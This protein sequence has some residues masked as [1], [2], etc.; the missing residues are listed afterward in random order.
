M[1]VLSPLLM[2]GLETISDPE[3]RDRFQIA[4]DGLNRVYEQKGEVQFKWTTT[5]KDKQKATR[6]KARSQE[7]PA[8][9]PREF[10]CSQVEVRA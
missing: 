5:L 6:R 8:S 7:D 2:K 10:K 4:L 3:C 9:L 1:P